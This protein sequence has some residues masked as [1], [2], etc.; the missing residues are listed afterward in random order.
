M[1]S[2]EN[3]YQIN[4]ENLTSLLLKKEKIS[5]LEELLFIESKK[6]E[7]LK[8]QKRKL[9]FGK[10]ICYKELEQ[11]F[12]KL[13]KEVDDFLDV[14][15]IFFPN[16]KYLSNIENMALSPKISTYA[17]LYYV[18]SI[19]NFGFL[20]N[21]LSILTNKF[22]LLNTLLML[23]MI[24]CGI[25]GISLHS[26]VDSSGY[27][28]T[29]ESIRIKKEKRANLIPVLAH[30]YTH[31]IQ[32]KKN[33]GFKEENVFIEG[34]ARGV[35]RYI[36]ETY[37]ER[38]NNDAFLYE[39]LG[40][41]VMEIKNCYIWASKKLKEPLKKSLLKINTL[42]Y[43]YGW[44]CMREGKPTEH[45]IGNALFSIYEKEYGNKIYREMIHGNFQFK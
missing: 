4:D 23:N 38:E 1:K 30:E 41:D 13:K 25:S 6:L 2:L 33:F 16:I 19:S 27:F 36:A 45:A 18:L 21:N 39:N 37:R 9:D 29:R 22:P 7:S 34:H 12:P 28:P 32:C 14:Q 24:I 35:Q 5:A 11:F 20:L 40:I 17:G 8:K 26:R 43:P 15:N 44:V 31:H 10:K 3:F 42:P